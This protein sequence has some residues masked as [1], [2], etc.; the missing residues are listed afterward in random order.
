MSELAGRRKRQRET[1]SNITT[2]NICRQRETPTNNTQQTNTA[3]NIHNHKNQQS[4][5]RETQ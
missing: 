5:Q 1:T 3:Q 4:Q 2:P